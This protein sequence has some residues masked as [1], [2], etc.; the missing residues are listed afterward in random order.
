MVRSVNLTKE[1]IIKTENKSGIL[2]DIAKM[3]AEHGINIE[4]MAGYVTPEDFANLMIVTDD[5]R[6][7]IDILKKKGY[8][9]L[10]EHEVISILVENKPG[11]LKIIAEILAG[12]GVDIRYNYGTMAL[13]AVASRMII[14]TSDNEKAV[15]LLERFITKE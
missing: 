5:E 11:A 1:I 6:R 9:T 3:T 4:A 12:H 8:K 15:A 7:T 13:D 14:G 10:V 2:A